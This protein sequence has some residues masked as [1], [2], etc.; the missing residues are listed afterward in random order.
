V[1]STAPADGEWEAEWEGQ[2]QPQEARGRRGALEGV[3]SRGDVGRERARG[4][5]GSVAST[6]GDGLDI[7]SFSIRAGST[8]LFVGAPLS[9]KAGRKYCFL[10]PN[11][12]GKSTLP[13]HIAGRA[14]ANIPTGISILLVAQEA[15]ASS[16]SCVEVLLASHETRHALVAEEANLEAQLE[17]AGDDAGDD[18][19]LDAAAL[20]LI[21]IYKE[22][23]IL[24]RDSAE[25]QAR[26][27]LSR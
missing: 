1:R 21:E 18:A 19:E 16:V 11:G 17:A 25:S 2:A 4:T 10:D 27:I 14:L 13:A 22:L 5:G 26:T 3:R 8:D 6:L 7:P 23:E 20:R 9:P 24:G 15:H 12:K